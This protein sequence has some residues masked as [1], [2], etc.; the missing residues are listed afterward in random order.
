MAFADHDRRRV[1]AIAIGIAVRPKERVIISERR[2]YEDAAAE[3]TA[4]KTAA[5]ETI[6]PK[7]ATRPTASPWA[8]GCN[9]DR[10]WCI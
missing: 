4:P 3:T 8:T 10:A 9:K 7:S 6:A 2:P 5:T 1:I